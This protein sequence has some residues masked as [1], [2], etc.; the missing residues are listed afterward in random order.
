MTQSVINVVHECNTNPLPVPVAVTVE[1]SDFV[2]SDGEL[3]VS[4][5]GTQADTSRDVTIQVAEADYWL[6]YCWFIDGATI[7]G[8]ESLT[9]PTTPGVSN[10]YKVTDST[11]LAAFTIE[12]T[13]AWQGH[14]CAAIVGRVAQSD[15]IVLGV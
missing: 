2:W 8:A 4:L 12:N 14:L 7:T 13:P 5:S 6:L 10:F 3:T 15:V 11:G 1:E 9:P